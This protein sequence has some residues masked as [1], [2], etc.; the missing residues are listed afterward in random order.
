L[1]EFRGKKL[2]RYLLS[3]T[4]VIGSEHLPHTTPADACD[5]AV[6]FV[7]YRAGYEVD[8]VGRLVGERLVTGGSRVVQ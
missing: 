6:P 2:E 7:Q 5:D 4:E 1:L 8:S 3:E